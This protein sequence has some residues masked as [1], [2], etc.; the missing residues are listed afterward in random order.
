[1]ATLFIHSIA[2]VAVSGSRLTPEALAAI[3]TT[4]D[5]VA[6]VAVTA[7]GPYGAIAGGLLQSGKAIFNAVEGVSSHPDQLYLSISNTPDIE[8]IWPLDRNVYEISSG[9]I[10]RELGV[11]YITLFPTFPPIPRAIAGPLKIEFKNVIDVNFWEADVHGSDFMGRLTVD[12]HEVGQMRMRIVDGAGDGAIY[13]VVYNVEAPSV[14]VPR[15]VPL[16]GGAIKS[17]LAVLNSIDDQLAIFGKGMDNDLYWRSQMHNSWDNTTWNRL[18]VPHEGMHGSPAVVLDADGRIVVFVQGGDNAIWHKSQLY[19]NSDRWSEWASL[20][21]SVTS[22]PGV[23]LDRYGCLVVFARGDGEDKSLIHCWQ[24]RRNSEWMPRWSPLGGSLLSAPAAALDY[25]GKIVVV[26]Q[27]LNRSVWMLKQSGMGDNPN[28]PMVSSVG[29]NF[30]FPL[31]KMSK[32]AG[33]SGILVG[34]KSQIGGG[35][36]SPIPSPPRERTHGRW[37]NGWRSLGGV[38]SSVPSITKDA[39]GWL[40]VFAKGADTKP[41]NSAFH[42]YIDTESNDWY[43]LAGTLT[44]AVASTLTS[45]GRLTIFGVATHDNS[46]WTRFQT[47]RGGAWLTETKFV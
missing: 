37:S 41:D 35:S 44:S 10:V 11:E 46:V 15:W 3:N 2:C 1:M 22:S 19:R 40:M 6:S 33:K 36:A 20:G 4:I 16:V 17:D 31:V 32:L 38:V 13:S 34:P 21:G 28:D 27:G 9:Q 8:K 39:D 26:A 14:E 43:P 12:A 47:T 23:V 5:A 24:T 42:R 25:D 30:L 29:S 18:G 7:G 45:D